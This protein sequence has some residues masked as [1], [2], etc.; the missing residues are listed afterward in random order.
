MPCQ[1]ECWGL[2]HHISEFPKPSAVY[3][4]VAGR[5]TPRG[6]WSWLSSGGSRK[7][8]VLPG[9]LGS[10]WQGDRGHQPGTT[11]TAPSRTGGGLITPDYILITWS[12]CGSSSLQSD[13]SF[14]FFEEVNFKRQFMIPWVIVLFKLGETWGK[15]WI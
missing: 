1:Q 9:G 11:P 15:F 7:H 6:C 10:S 14:I 3:F 5:N 13:I 2:V 8:L 4:P 12:L